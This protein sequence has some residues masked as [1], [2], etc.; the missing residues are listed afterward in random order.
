MRRRPLRAAGFS[1][2]ELLIA[3]AI[4]GVLASIA[5]PRFRDMQL[6]SKRGEVFV[7]M[8]AIAVAEVTHRDLYG[9]WV[10]AEWNPPGAPT[11]VQRVWNPTRTGWAELE[12]APDGRVRCKYR[13]V[14]RVRNRGDWVRVRGQCDLDGDGRRA[15]WWM[16]VDPDRIG[17]NSRHMELRPNA[18]TAANVIY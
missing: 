2:I 11:R 1:L 5:I 15:N 16:D 18:A 14:H 13:V 17:T 8:K 4:I 3:V 6:R 10:A 9:T 7:N 12:W